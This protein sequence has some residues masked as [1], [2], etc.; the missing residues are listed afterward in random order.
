MGRSGCL[1]GSEVDIPEVRIQLP[2]NFFW[3]KHHSQISS[4]PV[5]RER[6]E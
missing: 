5:H 6:I 3:E 4:M 2:E 1:V